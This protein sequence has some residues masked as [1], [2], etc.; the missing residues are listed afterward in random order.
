MKVE[1]LWS[2]DD[3]LRK[4]EEMRQLRTSVAEKMMANYHAQLERER[5]ETMKDRRFLIIWLI[6]CLVL[7]FGSF[8]IF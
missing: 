5:I 1:I 6:I 2:E 8:L 4:R 3:E 7:L